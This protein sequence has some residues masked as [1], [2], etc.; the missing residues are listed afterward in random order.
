MIPLL[1]KP[2]MIS[3]RTFRAGCFLI[4]ALLVTGCGRG[5]G[6]IFLYAI[7]EDLWWVL[8][9]DLKI[10]SWNFRFTKSGVCEKRY[11][12]QNMLFSLS[13]PSPLTQSWNGFLSPHDFCRYVTFFYS[14]SWPHLCPH[15]LWL[16][17]ERGE[18]LITIALRMVPFFAH[19]GSRKVIANRPWERLVYRLTD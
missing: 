1:V 12:S 9:A 13:A 5:A 6:G 4:G 10:H 14:A 8:H 7:S 18:R 11:H 2:Q 15:Q 16:R 17:G 19:T 3:V